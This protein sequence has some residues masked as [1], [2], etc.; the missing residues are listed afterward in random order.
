MRRRFFAICEKPEGE[1]ADNRPPA[2]RGLKLRSIENTKW[3]R[4]SRATKLLSGI[5]IIFKIL[6]ISIRLIF[7]FKIFPLKNK[8]FKKTFKILDG[9]G[10][11]ICIQK[12]KS[13][14][15]KMAELWHK[16]CK[17]QALFTSFWDLTAIFLIVFFYRFWRFKKCFRAI[18]RVL[19]ENL[20]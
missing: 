8:T 18:F 9:N 1:G 20:T 7:F 3:R 2:V 12:F 5:F 4:I 10:W 16:T 19:S 11:W 17:K 14:S 13:I 15:S 6:K